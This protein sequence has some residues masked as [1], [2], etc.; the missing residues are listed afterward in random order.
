MLA[1]MRPWFAPV[2]AVLFALGCALYALA[3]TWWEPTQWLTC[4]W[5]HPDCLSNQWLLTWVADQLAH[6]R[7]LLHNDRYYWP[8][9]DAPV[10]AGNGDEGVLFL[11]FYLLFG[12]PAGVPYYALLVLTLNGVSGWALA[13]AAGAERWAALLA[14]P[15]IGLLPYALMAMGSG[16]L[17]QVSLCWMLFF[18]ASWLRFLEAPSGRWALLSAA[19]LAVTSF[20][21]WYYGFFGVLAG[22]VVLVVRV[23]W[24]RRLPDPKMLAR[25]SA[26][27]LIFLAPWAWF[28][29]ANWRLVPGSDEVAAFPHPEALNQVRPLHWPFLAREGMDLFHAMTLPGLLLALVGA[30]LALW[31]RRSADPPAWR[32]PAALGLAGVW[33]LFWALSLGP[34][35][36]HAPYTLL[37]G[38]AE[39][40]RRFWW[41]LRHEAMAQGAAA[42]LGALA[43]SSGLSRVTREPVRALIAIGVAQIPA[44]AFTLQGVSQHVQISR[45]VLPPPV[46]P[47]LAGRPGTGLI[48]PP[49]SPTLGG[50]QQ[51]LIYQ[52]YHHKTLLNGTA[53]WVDRVRPK[54]WDAFMANNSFL[55]E[56]QALERGE[57]ASGFTYRA[58]DL[59]ALTGAGFRWFSLNK[60]MFPV[61]MRELVASYDA[62]LNGLFGAPSIEQAGVSVWDM[63]RWKGK[64]E[65]PLR[66]FALPPG[67]GTAGPVNHRFPSPTFGKGRGGSNLPGEY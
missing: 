41:P 19:L 32:G 24:D 38:L 64:T 34:V 7:G 3:P 9:G 63:E 66:P 51:Q 36:P 33:G 46:Y 5:H 15:T 50:P 55:A 17:N 14:V 39:P 58:E 47:A 2:A 4:N 49:L 61:S 44:L 31:P 23:A 65:L 62:L 42:A 30:G 8:V 27:F 25:F 1:P 57:L 43:L 18:L 35:S 54:A 40:L 16:Q 45:V 60:E 29:A 12:W 6:G 53:L 22:F 28:F 13:R 52:L 59:Q 56:L 37:Y 48:E 67:L 11:P 21:Y 10:I 20:F 26:A